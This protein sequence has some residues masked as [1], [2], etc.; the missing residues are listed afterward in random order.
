[1]KYYYHHH[2]LIELDSPILDLSLLTH[3]NAS[4]FH[5][6]VPSTSLASGHFLFTC[7]L[8]SLLVDYHEFF[9]PVFPVVLLI[10]PPCTCVQPIPVFWVEYVLAHLCPYITHKF[11]YNCIFSNALLLCW[12]IYTFFPNYFPFKSS[13]GHHPSVACVAQWFGLWYYFL[14]FLWTWLKTINNNKTGI[15]EI[16]SGWQLL[17]TGEGFV[18]NCKV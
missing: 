13:K 14:L 6:G 5:R 1:M 3:S 9:L 4:L 10:Y 18:E 2:L 15:C 16:F 8:T 12:S 17:S 7:P 11:Y